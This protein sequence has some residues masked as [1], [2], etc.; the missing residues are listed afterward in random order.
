VVCELEAIDIV[1]TDQGVR[2]VDVEMLEKAGV[3]VIIAGA[4]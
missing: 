4:D 2:P 1:I 3:Q